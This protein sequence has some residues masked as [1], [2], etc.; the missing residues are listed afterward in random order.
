MTTAD[1]CK[2]VSIGHIRGARPGHEGAQ[3]AERRRRAAERRVQVAHFVALGRTNQRDLATE[4]GVS[5]GTINGDLKWLHQQWRERASEDIEAARGR[6]LDRLDHL[7]AALWPAAAAGALKAIDRVLACL[8]LRARL[9]GTTAPREVRI[10]LTSHI[11]TIAAA[12]GLAEAEVL[13]L[14]E[15]LLH[16][17]HH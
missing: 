2:P 15:R 16:E 13:E 8:T 5:L 9:L 11:R 7:L 10:D 17:G 6:D 4:L 1:A 14:A 12:S 3:R